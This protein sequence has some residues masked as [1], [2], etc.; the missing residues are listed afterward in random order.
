MALAQNVIC[1]SVR[2][3]LGTEAPIMMPDGIDYSP[4]PCNTCVPVP[5]YKTQ[6]RR[7]LALKRSPV[8]LYNQAAANAKSSRYE[9]DR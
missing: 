8:A 2:L 3:L 1:D 5:S 4:H 6:V 7:Q 9:V